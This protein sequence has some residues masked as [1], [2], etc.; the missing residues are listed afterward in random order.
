MG[1]VATHINVSPTFEAKSAMKVL[2]KFF[3]SFREAA[4]ISEEMV[5]VPTDS[6]VK[7]VDE[8]IASEHP[9]LGPLGD[10]IHALNQNVV[11]TDAKVKEGDTLAIF[12]IVGGG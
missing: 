7:D 2:V 4:G 11:D 12:P 1:V 10:A 8:M 9:D 3:A 6:T 5:E